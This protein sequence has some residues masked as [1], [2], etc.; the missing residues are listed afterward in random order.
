MDQMGTD[1]DETVDSWLV[2]VVDTLLKSFH[3]A[4][5]AD[6]S[7]D[8]VLLIDEYKKSGMPDGNTFGDFLQW[9]NSLEDMHT[10][11]MQAA[12]EASEDDNE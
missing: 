3:R 8:V 2:D 11:E 10:A 6:G 4:S 5:F 9:A 1:I 7:Y 12:L